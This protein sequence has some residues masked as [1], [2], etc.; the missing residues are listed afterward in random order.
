MKH[1]SNNT[2]GIAAL[3]I[4]MC[5]VINSTGCGST[6]PKTTKEDN[7]ITES[8]ETTSDEETVEAIVEENSSAAS[9]S[10]WDN[11][12]NLKDAADVR[13]ENG[14]VV[15]DF[16]DF[17]IT[18]SGDA[19]VQSIRGLYQDKET[20][21]L[22]FIVIHQMEDND[23]LY[24]IGV[25]PKEYNL[26]GYEAI[27][28]KNHY[29]VDSYGN[30]YYF[31]KHNTENN[32]YIAYPDKEVYIV[33]NYTDNMPIDNI[34]IALKSQDTTVET[35][36]TTQ[37]TENTTVETTDTSAGDVLLGEPTE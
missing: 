14:N 1:Y 16:G 25:Y 15:Y 21:Y 36:D 27:I 32:F 24:G 33:V 37:S 3:I 13:D 2:V 7:T 8:V 23:S 29:Q 6:K 22:D 28:T 17:E 11:Y 30:H 35:T 4:M 31:A 12:T 18:Y 26:E 5:C 34:A 19:E 20:D 10:N 9:E